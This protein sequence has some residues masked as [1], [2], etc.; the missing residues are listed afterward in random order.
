MARSSEKWK[1]DESFPENPIQIQN[2]L[3]ATNN[4]SVVISVFVC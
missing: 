3:K 1:H 2:M 4:M